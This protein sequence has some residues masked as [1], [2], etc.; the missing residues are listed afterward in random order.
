[1]WIQKFAQPCIKRRQG[2][3]TIPNAF[4]VC[5]GI[6]ICYLKFP[7]FPQH[8]VMLRPYAMTTPADLGNT[9]TFTSTSGELSRGQRSS[10]T[11]WRNQEFADRWEIEDGQ[12]VSHGRSLYHAIAYADVSDEITFHCLC[13]QPMRGTTIYST[14]CLQAWALIRRLN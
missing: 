12:N 4:A 1:M 8:S 5:R 3:E 9:L 6:E 10:S 2:F 7:L 14:V 13:R 11:C